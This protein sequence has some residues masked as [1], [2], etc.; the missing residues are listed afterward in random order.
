MGMFTADSEGVVPQMVLR[1]PSA[2]ASR[3]GAEPGG[4]S[5]VTPIPWRR[6]RCTSCRTVFYDAFLER[7]GMAFFSSLVQKSMRI[8]VL[9]LLGGGALREPTM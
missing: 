9:R 1:C 7:L 8:T 6:K 4:P 3:R 2:R 5:V